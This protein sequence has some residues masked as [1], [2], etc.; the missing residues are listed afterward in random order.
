[1]NNG[2]DE[3][4]N[5]QVRDR[6][7]SG[8]TFVS[9]RPSQGS[10]DSTT[11]FWTVGTVTTSAPLTL[12]LEG[13]VV[14]PKPQ[15]DA[16]RIVQADQF[17]PDTGNN[18][19]A[20]TVTPQQADLALSKPVNDPTPVVGETIT[21]TVTL[22]NSGPD[23]AT[24]VQVTDHLPAGLSFVSATPSQGTYNPGLGRWTVG[25]VAVGAPDTLLI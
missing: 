18:T 17:D 2:P 9:A 24:D 6:L 23:A 19:A 13:V 11:G 20:A 22:S 14:S 21:Y 5:V 16:A 7:P 8:M 12:D 25:T 15:V 3:A 4:T 10:Y 1:S